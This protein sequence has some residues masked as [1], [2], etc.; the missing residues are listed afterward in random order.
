MKPSN[1]KS[2][3]TVLANKLK[4]KLAINIRM[5]VPAPIKL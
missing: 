4:L 5:P 3:N 1:E 2:K